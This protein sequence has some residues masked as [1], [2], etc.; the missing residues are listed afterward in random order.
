MLQNMVTM[1]VCLVIVSISLFTNSHYN[2]MV[3]Q[4]KWSTLLLVIITSCYFKIRD[5]WIN[6][7]LD[8]HCATMISINVLNIP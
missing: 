1:K 4:N 5:K 3:G 6:Y 8:A 7:L 2:I